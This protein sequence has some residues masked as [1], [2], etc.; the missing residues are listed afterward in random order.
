MTILKK[1]KLTNFFVWVFV[2]FAMYMTLQSDNK[3][4]EIIITN[5]L[6]NELIASKGQLGSK[7]TTTRPR[8]EELV[9][10]RLGVRKVEYNC[11]FA[12]QIRR[13]YQNAKND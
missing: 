13:Y 7:M 11:G 3:I 10:I 9:T 5:C 8:I 2:F 6:T 4:I 12:R 1:K